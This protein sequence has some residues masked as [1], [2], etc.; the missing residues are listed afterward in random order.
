MKKAV[1]WLLVGLVLGSVATV[2]AADYFTAAPAGFPILV[3][4]VRKTF[5]M[6]AVSINGSTYMPLRALGEA[7]GE[8][9]KWNAAKNRVEIGNDMNYG[10]YGRL[11]IICQDVWRDDGKPQQRP[12]A[13]Y[14]YLIVRLKL[15]NKSDGENAAYALSRFTLR[16]T[17]G[18]AY[19][20]VHNALYK[21]DDA[22]LALYGEVQYAVPVIGTAVFEIP[23]GEPCY[24]LVYEEEGLSLDPCYLR[25]PD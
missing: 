6:P 10:E 21:A 12:Q 19:K 8:T 11:K 23:L 2:G 16:D 5:D 24:S 17:A 25:L 14:E 18:R 15:E 7:L 3:N 4:G 1:F 22:D 9:V 20:P 13:G